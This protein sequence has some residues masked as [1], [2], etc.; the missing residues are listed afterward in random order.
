LAAGGAGR[1]HAVRFTGTPE[2]HAVPDNKNVQ[3]WLREGEALYARLLSN[4]DDTERQIEALESSLVAKAAEINHLAR[5]LGK[6]QMS[7][8]RRV[9]AELLTPTT[10]AE[11]ADDADPVVNA[12]RVRASRA[13]VNAKFATERVVATPAAAR[14]LDAIPG[15]NVD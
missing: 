7:A 10:D 4:Y 14:I 2:V 1:Y 5:L 6:P 13:A 8:G 9:A 11:T 15:R 3:D 12:T